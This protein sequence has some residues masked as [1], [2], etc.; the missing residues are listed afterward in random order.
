ML[1]DGG[2]IARSRW[3]CRWVKVALPPGDGGAAAG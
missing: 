1:C 3:P 2:P